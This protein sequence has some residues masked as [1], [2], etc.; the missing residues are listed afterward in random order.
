MFRSDDADVHRSD[1][2]TAVA[3]L[4]TCNTEHAPSFRAN[5][6]GTSRRR[7]PRQARGCTRG[8]T[9]S[10]ASW[11]RPS[12]CCLSWLAS[13]WPLLR[14]STS[15][16]LRFTPWTAPSFQSLSTHD[17]KGCRQALRGDSLGCGGDR[18]RIRPSF[19][20]RG[21]FYHCV[22]GRVECRRWCPQ[23]GCPQGLSHVD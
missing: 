7:A 13:Q 19:P 21:A 23:Q 17:M 1:N 14:R 4:G 8:S 2:A 10:R 6:A 15:Y 12:R 3:Y 20:G 9:G 5:V 18:E 16:S 22:G 11:R